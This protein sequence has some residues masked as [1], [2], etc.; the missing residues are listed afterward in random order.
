MSNTLAVQQLLK[1]VSGLHSRV[2]LKLR[3]LDDTHRIRATTTQPPNPL[4][5]ASW[6]GLINLCGIN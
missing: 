5:E 4:P 1:K 6:R 2:R 3:L